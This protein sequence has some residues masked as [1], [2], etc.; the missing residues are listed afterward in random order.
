ML[1]K[2]LASLVG[3][4]GPLF[5]GPGG[6]ALDK[7]LVERLQQQSSPI[8]PVEPPPIIEWAERVSGLQL[9]LWQKQV[10]TSTAQ[11]FLM[12]CSRQVG[13]TEVVS[14]KSAYRARHLRRRVVAIAPSLYQSSKIRQ[15]AQ[16]YLEADGATFAVMNATTLE[17]D[18]GGSIISLPGDR[19]DLSARSETTD[20]LIVDEA[21]RVKDALISAITPTTATR[22]NATVTYLSTPA[23]K[24]G[25]FYRAWTDESGAWERYS[26]KATE[27]SRITADFLRRQRAELGILFAQ[28]FECA[29]IADS[30]AVLDPALIERIFK[31]PGAPQ[32]D[33]IDWMNEQVRDEWDVD[34]GAVLE[35]KPARRVNGGVPVA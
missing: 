18:G 17:L 33:S 28:E 13:K 20:D 25:A 11:Y 9:D 15:R 1:D 16:R 23:G 12:N 3:L 27:C 30:S 6:A 31:S 2:Q 32:A 21:S 4:F 8:R 14:L 5:G 34:F 24:R 7:L 10:L 29:F 22:P 19:P 26:I 35:E